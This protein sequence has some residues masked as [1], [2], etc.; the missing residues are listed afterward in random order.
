MQPKTT[1]I[2]YWII[3]GLLC[4]FFAFDGVG[5]V[6]QVEAG[7]ESLRALGYTSFY[8]LT[9]IG[10]AKLLGVIALLQP[11]FPRLKEWAYAGFV[12]NV[13]GAA[14]S[15]IFV[16]GPAFNSILPLVFLALIL[17]SYCLWKKMR[18]IPCQ[19]V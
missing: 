6:L 10:A 16:R 5:G 3:T 8:V 13:L 18:G 15:W 19:A 12:I 2:T 7:K 9:M 4:A 17:W 1:K 14:V 11:K